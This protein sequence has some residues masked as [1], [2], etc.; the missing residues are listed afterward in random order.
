[1]RKIRKITVSDGI[2]WV[3]VAEAGVY[4]LCGCPADSI[5]HL[6]K[7]GLV[8]PTEADGVPFETGPNAILLSDV[9]LQ[10]GQFANM[11][12]FPVLQM[13]YRQG[14]ILPDHP[15]NTGQ[16]PLLMGLREQVN[17]QMEYIHRGNYGLASID[18]MVQAGASPDEA[19]EL[20]RLKL[21]FA[22]GSIRDSR[23]FIDPL[24]IE[25]EREEILNGVGVKRLGF[26]K[27]AFDY[28]DETVV[29]DL[30][31]E[32][33]ESYCAPYPLGHH[34]VIREYFAV[35][36]TGEGDGWDIDRP[37]M[38]SILMYHGRMFLI[39]AGPNIIQ[40][41]SSLGIG[42]NE[43]EGIFHTHSHDDHFA[44]L[45]ALLRSDHRI[46]YYATPLVRASVTRKLSA[47]LS[48]GE[49]DFAHYFDIHDLE[50]DAWN[51]IEG[52]E[53]KPLL[54]PHPVENSV[55]VFRTMW[56]DGYRSYAHFADTVGLEVLDAMVGDGPGDVSP[57]FADKVR[58]DYMVEADVKKLDIGG[59]MI[60]GRAEDFRKDPSD[61]IVL[62]HTSKTFTDEEKEIGS[63]APFGTVDTLIP[64]HQ[65][66]E[67]RQAFEFLN[68]YFPNAP[69][70]HLRILLNHNVV[71]FNP[72]TIVLKEGERN[73][74]MYLLLS[75]IVDAIRADHG[76]R[77]TLYAG[78]LIGEMAGLKG[79]P[80]PHTFRAESFAKA[81]RIPSA[82]YRRF[83]KLNDLWD[84]IERL[85]ARREF[86]D[87][88]WLF[89][90]AMS[91]AVQNRIAQ[92]L[93]PVAYPSG[94]E[95]APDED[96]GLNMIRKGTLARL[97]G[98]D[99][100]E[101][102]AKGDFFGEETAVFGTPGALTVRALE[103]VE[104][105]RIPGDI[106]RNIPI[107]RWK[108]FETHERRKRLVAGAER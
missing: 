82:L 55:F 75:G 11:A 21:K 51:D 37:C 69:M 8:A 5:K 1:M 93:V 45:P 88:T 26:N 64:S 40:T 84:E 18:E 2:H 39:D 74:D 24:F 14:M 9:M 23:D 12:E 79:E 106:L 27:F 22:F 68:A 41:L 7:R 3:E 107:A 105:Y 50:I 62:S 32:P 15:N 65:R 91:Q 76:I 33:L 104:I 31:L 70:H 13:L 96:I 59:G 53:V 43:I 77:H 61:K 25:D 92:K 56:E 19:D 102:L 49:E 83:V 90:E 4:V 101:T 29:V 67:H 97:A 71:T 78:T 35:L 42:V 73:E 63:G 47:L 28:Q 44:G 85:R 94:Y 98:D 10:N 86:L 6:L 103:P 57:A 46:K 52:L 72:E 99:V 66:F 30:T 20:M 54:S 108:M 81:L 58:A 89:G 36:H 17:S 95:F 38:S 80:L 48:I 87:T 100:L 16:K 34:N 60:H